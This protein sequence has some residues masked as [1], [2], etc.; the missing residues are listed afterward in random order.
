MLR[1]FLHKGTSI[2]NLKASKHN[3]ALFSST[4]LIVSVYEREGLS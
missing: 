4:S 1:S 2:P 3:D